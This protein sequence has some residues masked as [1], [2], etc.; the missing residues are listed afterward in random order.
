M[1][2]RM[3]IPWRLK[4]AVKLGLSVLPVPYAAWRRLALFR[5]G[6]MDDPSYAWGEL[7]THLTLSGMGAETAPGAMLELGPGDALTTAVAGAALGFSPIHLVDVGAFARRDLRPYRAAE[8]FLRARGYSPPDLR[9]AKTLESILQ[10]CGAFY[11][12]NGLESLRSLPDGSIRFAWS[13]AVLEHVP[14]AGFRPL[15]RELRRVLQ[16]G[17]VSS[18]SVDF[19]DHL[20][21][22][23]NHLRF[24]A[25]TWE[26]PRVARSGFYTNRIGFAAMQTLFQE[27]GFLVEAREVHR[28]PALPTPRRSLDPEFRDRSDEDLCVSAALF[29]LRPAILP[30][31][32]GRP[33][34]SHRAG[35]N[36][37]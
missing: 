16:P 22:G 17:G 30:V 34:G 19:R 32:A 28:W 3:A 8:A 2:F 26:S 37:R 12:T 24:S 35:A 20:G 7:L 29:V 10:A 14:R 23:L 1:G 5:H 13:S 25:R 9:E 27:A 33:P 15:L 36:E 21:E 4:M 31:A 18:H 11:A 6:E